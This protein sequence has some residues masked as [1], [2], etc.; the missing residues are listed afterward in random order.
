M[1]LGGTQNMNCNL[2][3]FEEKVIRKTWEENQWYFSIEN[4]VYALTNLGEEATV[5]FYQKNNSW[6]LEKQKMI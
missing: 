3:S 4:I 5:E 2:A 6:S 1:L